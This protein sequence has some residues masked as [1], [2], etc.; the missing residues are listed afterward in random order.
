MVHLEWSLPH[1]PNVE[2]HTQHFSLLYKYPPALPERDS[3]SLLESTS[4]PLSDKE[5]CKA[6]ICSVPFTGAVNTD[7]LPSPTLPSVANRVAVA[8]VCCCF[9]S[10]SYA[11]SFSRKALYFMKEAWFGSQQQE[12]RRRKYQCSS[13]IRNTLIRTEGPLWWWKA[14]SSPELSYATSYAVKYTVPWV[15]MRLIYQVLRLDDP[16]SFFPVKNYTN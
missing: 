13:F 15:N 3:L 12:S 10:L 9:A 5:Q 4:S 2:K 6:S 7:R 14:F 16:L 11:R 1:T 8:S